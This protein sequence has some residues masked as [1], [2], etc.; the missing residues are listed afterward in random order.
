MIEPAPDREQTGGGLYL[1]DRARE[2]KSF[3]TV[4]DIAADASVMFTI[5]DKV[6]FPDHQEYRIT[7]RD[8]AYVFVPH[9]VIIAFESNE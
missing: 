7:Y 9:N 2:R 4:I 6:I 8:K 3:G 5:G 1:P